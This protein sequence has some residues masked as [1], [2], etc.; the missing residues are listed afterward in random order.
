MGGTNIVTLSALR[1][2]NHIYSVQKVAQ[3]VEGENGR[4]EQQ[5]M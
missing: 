3:I 2:R 1:Y 5:W 4:G